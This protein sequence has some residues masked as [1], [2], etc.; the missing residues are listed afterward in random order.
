MKSAR[1][2]LRLRG[3]TFLGDSYLFPEIGRCDERHD[4]CCDDVLLHAGG[5]GGIKDT[6]GTGDGTL[7]S[8]YY[9]I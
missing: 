8:L 4:A 2:T 3:L 1:P 7:E 9:I 6:R 5:E